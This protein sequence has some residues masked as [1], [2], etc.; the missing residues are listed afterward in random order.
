MYDYF[1]E[2]PVAGNFSNQ[3]TKPSADSTF[4]KVNN[5]C[6]TCE[7]G[8]LIIITIAQIAPGLSEPRPCAQ[9]D[10]ISVHCLV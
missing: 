7:H 2:L 3:Y 8:S 4:L 5:I 9:K 1:K 6:D 10:I